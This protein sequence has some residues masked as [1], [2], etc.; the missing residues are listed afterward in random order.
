MDEDRAALSTSPLDD[1]NTLQRELRNLVH[2]QLQLAAL[3]VRLAAKSL[4]IMVSAAICIGALMVLAW[5]SLM[6]AAGLGLVLMGIQPALALLVL[7]AF[8]LA[9]ALLLGGFIRHR[10]RYL[11]FP[12]SLRTLNPSASDHHNR[13]TT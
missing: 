1:L 13:E 7:A 8:T 10:S 3:E 2:D 4:I 12:A 11:G 5:V 9:L 6:G